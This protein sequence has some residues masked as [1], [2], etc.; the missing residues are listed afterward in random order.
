[1]RC[2]YMTKHYTGNP[3]SEDVCVCEGEREKEEKG[4]RARVVEVEMNWETNG[5]LIVALCGALS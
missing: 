1:M 3:S 5:R 4:S 2:V